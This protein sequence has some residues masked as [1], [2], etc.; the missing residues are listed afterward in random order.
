MGAISRGF[1]VCKIIVRFGYSSLHLR[2]TLKNLKICFFVPACCFKGGARPE[3]QTFD[4]KIPHSGPIFWSCLEAKNSLAPLWQPRP[5][6]RQ[7]RIFKS[8]VIAHNQSIGNIFLSHHQNLQPDWTKNI[9]VMIKKP[10]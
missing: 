4:S 2:Y 9:R 10:K 7:N 8:I 6:S 1:T 3:I 5:L